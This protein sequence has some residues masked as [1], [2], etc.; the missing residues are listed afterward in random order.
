MF[1][2]GVN[3]TSS[4][5]AH[6]AP[7]VV[8]R[9]KQARVT[10]L[11]LIGSDIPDSEQALALANQ[12]PDYCFA[13]AGIHPHHAKDADN[14]SL[15]RL[16]ELLS[17][18]NRALVALGECGLDF[19]R[20]FSPP[21]DQ[22]RIFSQQ[23]ELAAKLKRPIYMHCR[24]AHKHFIELLRPWV[25]KIP[26]MLLHC[27]TGNREELEECLELGL[28]IGITG[29]VCDE[30]RG[31]ELRQLVP[32]IPDERLLIETDAPYLLPR[33]LSPKPKS[34][35]NE[36]CYLSHILEVVALLRQQSPEQLRDQLEQNCRAFFSLTR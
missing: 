29:W 17:D 12:W 30:R 28:M 32:L 4:Q 18:R 7:E 13:T 15:E 26:G 19:N 10:G 11:I 1:D 2:I 14:S 23:L 6:D 35:R 20:N 3:L 33:D 8:A 25:G 22:E 34:R 36:P 24:D 16:E 9:A 5:F 27:F 31:Q 21:A